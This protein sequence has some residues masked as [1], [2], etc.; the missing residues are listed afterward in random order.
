MRQFPAKGPFTQNSAQALASNLILSNL[1]RP[2]P[3]L[4]RPPIRRLLDHLG[5]GFPLARS[6]TDD[7]NAARQEGDGGGKAIISQRQSIDEARVLPVGVD[8]QPKAD[9][10]DDG[11]GGLPIRIGELVRVVVGVT[12]QPASGSEPF[13]FVSACVHPAVPFWMN[14]IG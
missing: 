3:R 9:D 13:Q 10:V 12:S 1:L 8:R 2:L 5:E 4:R 6:L 11:L 14:S 7:A